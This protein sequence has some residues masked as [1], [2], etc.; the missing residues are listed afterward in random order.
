MHVDN[1]EEVEKEWKQMFLC[2]GLRDVFL[3]SSSRCQDPIDNSI[4]RS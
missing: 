4:P 2:G 1:V 3:L